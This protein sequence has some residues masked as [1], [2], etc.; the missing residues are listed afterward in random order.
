[1]MLSGCGQGGKSMEKETTGQA[2]EQLTEIQPESETK[3]V[4]EEAPAEAEETETEPEPMVTICTGIESEILERDDTFFQIDWLDTYLDASEFSL[5]KLD[6]PTVYR[7]A[8]CLYR[9]DEAKGWTKEDWDLVRPLGQ[10]TTTAMGYGK[11]D[12]NN[13]GKKEYIYRT[14][15]NGMTAA[16][17]KVS[18]D[19]K[20]IIGEYNLLDVFA[21]SY[22]EK[23][24][25]LQLWFGEF[26]DSVVSFAFLEN[27][28]TTFTV[29]AFLV[30][31]D[32]VS[33]L[34]KRR[35]YVKTKEVPES[36][37]YS[38]ENIYASQSQLW[39]V[40]VD[41]ITACNLSREEIKSLR[42]DRDIKIQE[43]ETGLPEEL[44]EALQNLLI[45]EEKDEEGSIDDCLESYQAKECELNEDYVLELLENSESL[46]EL[47]S[48]E[49]A[50]MAD[51]DGDGKEEIILCGYYGGNIPDWSIE[52]WSESEDG[53]GKFTRMD[54]G[55][56]RRARLFFTL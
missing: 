15:E 21:Q 43:Q 37:A 42:Q 48:A 16:G 22:D 46:E 53:T 39:D 54:V 5:I 17:Y 3:E 13:D 34:E 50:Y 45:K 2:A 1:M 27:T 52:I 28:E 26:E 8:P 49:D 47:K 4:T 38:D 25:P 19:G 44:V 9:E 14:V 36:E 12:Y 30:A 51:L 6:C 7:M 33:V 35:L 20:S 24:I 18:E 55:R 40:V 41:D 23:K 31:G 29:Y 32:S 56:G 10:T 11:I